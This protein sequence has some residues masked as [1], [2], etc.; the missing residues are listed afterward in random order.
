MEQKI[1]KEDKE[2]GV[3]EKILNAATELFA[4]SGYHGT[5]MKDIARL[6]GVNKALLFYY[7]NSKENLH[8]EIIKSIP[9]SLMKCIDE[10]MR[11]INDSFGQLRA[12]IKGY[13]RH[14]SVSRYKM[15]IM[16]QS[17]LGIGPES[18]IRMEELLETSRKPIV[19]VLENGVNLGFFKEMNCGFTSNAILGM[20]Q[21]FYR[22]PSNTDREYSDDEILC[23]IFEII[24]KGILTGVKTDE[25]V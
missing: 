6:A 4:M 1:E 13:I 21:I 19:D 9:E 10:E 8:H 17:F 12:V 16:V 20:I 15:R 22:I 11:G 14:F 2:I 24:E 7:F 25:K 23:N 5:S 3:R 18:P